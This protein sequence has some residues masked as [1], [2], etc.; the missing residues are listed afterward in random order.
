MTRDWDR[1]L[2]V[3]I[4]S[5]ADNPFLRKCVSRF[6]MRLG[7]ARFVAGETLD[8]FAAVA[9]GLN[10]KGM[11]VAAGLLGE[12]TKNAD[13]ALRAAAQYQ[14][15]LNR[16]DSD[17]LRA[18]IAL[19]LTHMGLAIDEELSYRN[20]KMLASHAGGN[21][22]RIDMEESRYV[23]ATLDT[24]RRLRS[25]GHDNVGTVIQ[26]YL[27][28]SAADL[29]SLMPLEPNLRIVK[30]AYLEPPSLA[31]PKKRDVDEN[32]ARLMEVSLSGGGYTAIATHDADLIEHALEF[33]RARSIAE[34]KYEFQML[35]GVRPQLQASLAVRRCPLRIAVPFGTQWYP[36]LMRRLA[37]RPANLF[38]FLR[39]LWPS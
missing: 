37:E 34:D 11:R 24:Y 18:N 16:I 21:L 28:R 19:K 4:L 2:R 3:A 32:F 9:Q 35:Y 38:F 10:R 17:H 33:T 15:V 8:Q 14:L 22:V 39:A 5:A 7:A 31:Y 12:G 1:V 27:Y 23:D 36:Y 26:A 30:G 29:R 25:A 20:V 6:G 13:H